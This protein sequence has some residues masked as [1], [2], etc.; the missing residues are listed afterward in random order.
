[1]FFCGILFIALLCIY[2]YMYIWIYGYMWVYGYMGIWKYGYMDIWIYICIYG[3]IYI[4]IKKY[5]W[6]NGYKRP[7]FPALLFPLQRCVLCEGRQNG[8]KY[9]MKGYPG[10]KDVQD[11]RNGTR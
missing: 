11:G 4:Y 1:M 3:Y 8:E 7:A 5:I 6:A 2:V 10:R 9:R